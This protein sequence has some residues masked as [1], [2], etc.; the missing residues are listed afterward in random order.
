M[1]PTDVKRDAISEA[2]RHAAFV[3]T[4]GA[5]SDDAAESSPRWRATAAGFLVLR[6]LDTWATE[7]CV[8][9]ESWRATMGA[10]AKVPTSNPVRALLETVARAAGGSAPG[11]AGSPLVP[12]TAY[13]RA[14]EFDAEWALAA[15][16]YAT[17]AEYAAA[18]DAEDLIPEAYHRLGYCRRLLGDLNA[19][20]TAFAAGRLAASA[21]GNPDAE[22]WL[23]LSESNLLT[24]RGNLPA[25]AA[26]L[27]ALVSDA[28]S[29]GNRQLVTA[30]RHDRAHVAYAQG[31]YERATLL[32]YAAAEAYVDPRRKARALA[33]VATGAAALGH[34][35]LARRVHEIVHATAEQRDLRWIAAVN[36]LEDA[37]AE[38]RETVFESYRSALESEALPVPLAATY[39]LCTGQGYVR[40]GR[41]SAARESFTQAIRIAEA[42]SLNQIIM[43]ADAALAALDTP[44]SAPT[45]PT[46]APYTAPM[47]WSP[48]VERLAS[49][50]D[51]LHAAAV[52]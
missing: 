34:R 22:L 26:S 2:L 1:S 4:L 21:Q 36:L 35:D 32:F 27:D 10:V 28:E 3:A 41:S 5:A 29:V 42:A 48:A 19:A 14:L 12:L 18:H 46:P 52:R 8:H 30:A 25:A 16:V 37:V 6:Q 33:D 15:D 20:A 43:L 17:V 7:G 45:P 31:E 44:R 49:A 50:V 38:G 40:F 47:S 24:H 51:K 23:R 39:H 13:A 9:A 11:H